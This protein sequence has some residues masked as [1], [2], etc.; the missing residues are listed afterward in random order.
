MVGHQ[1]NFRQRVMAYNVKSNRSE[2]HNVYFQ[3]VAS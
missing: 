3:E 2:L 1:V